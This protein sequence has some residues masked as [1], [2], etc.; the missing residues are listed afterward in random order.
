MWGEA[1]H[2]IPFNHA[3]KFDSALVNSQVVSY[4]DAGHVPM[5]ELPIR[6]ATDAMAFLLE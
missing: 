4:A 2:W 6:S 5:E 3:A 1:D